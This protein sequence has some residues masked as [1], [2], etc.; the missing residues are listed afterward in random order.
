MRRV[1]LDQFR[2][3][4]VL[5]MIAANFMQDARFIVEGFPFLRHAQ[6]GFG[7]S[8]SIMPQFFFAV[9]YA[10]RLTFLRRLES[11][12]RQ[13]ASLKAVRRSLGLLLMG[14]VLYGLDGNYK[15]WA[16]IQS[17]GLGGFLQTAFQREYF[18]TLT[19]IGFTLLWILPVIA[20]NWQARL[21]YG[22]ASL[23]IYYLLSQGFYFDWAIRRPVI[24][25]GPLGFLSWSAPMLAGAWAHD[26]IEGNRDRRLLPAVGIVW[27]LAGFALSRYSNA[28][29]ALTMSQRAGSV[30]YQLFGAGF[31]LAV[32]SLFA[33]LCDERNWRSDFLNTF[34]TNALAAYI[35][36]DLISQFVLR[37]TPSDGPAAYILLMLSV[38]IALCYLFLRALEKN[39][40]FLRL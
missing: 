1:S 22:A 31:S 36:G 4:T 15:S 28:L 14:L 17:L 34:G 13:A 9:G 30:S 19:H 10:F 32:Y 2:G 33:W 27:M 29:I 24:D 37:W 16:E 6:T 12:G 20:L 3:Y 8:D 21:I 25:G 18:Q 38:Q 7:Y 35:V 23:L 5:G 11:D 40:L 39:R 26:V